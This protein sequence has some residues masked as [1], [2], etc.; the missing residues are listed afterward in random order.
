MRVLVDRH[1]RVL[2]HC[3]PKPVAIENVEINVCPAWTLNK[4]RVPVELQ[5]HVALLVSSAAAIT[6]A[7]LLRFVPHFCL[8]Q[9]LFGVPCPGC[10][11]LHSATALLR[12][13][14]AGAWRANPAGFGVL[15]VLLFQLIARPAAILFARTRALVSITSSRLANAAL[16][17][18]FMIWI[19]RLISGGLHGSSLLS[20]M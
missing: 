3:W 7:P 17:W 14:F 11:I 5:L 6:A 4:L 13:D 2:Y 15:A 9:K 8:V 18:L 10:G 16:A 19:L 20:K 12:L 1:E